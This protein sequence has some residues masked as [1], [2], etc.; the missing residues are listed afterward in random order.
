MSYLLNEVLPGLKEGW[1][2]LVSEVLGFMSSSFG[3]TL[4]VDTNSGSDNN[5]GGSPEKAFATIQAAVTAGTKLT[6][7]IV[8][9]KNMSA[10]DTDPGSYTENIVIPA[11]KW[12]MRIIGDGF[13]NRTQGG[14]PQLKVGSTT[15]QALLTIR[16]PGVTIAGLGFNGTGATGG[17]I[18]L[19][20]DGSTKTA[21]GTS[22][23]GCHFK[24][25]VGT[26][27]TNAATGGAIQW[28]AAGG[29]WQVR[30]A[31]NRFYKNVGDIVLLGT[32]GS[33]PQDVIIEDNVFS[34]PAANVDCNLYLAGGSGMNGVVIRNNDFPCFP[35]IGS[36]TNAKQLALT[37]CVGSLVGNTFGCSAKTFGAT[38]DNLV[39][40]TV[41][42]SNNYQECA[43]AASGEIGRT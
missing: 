1:K 26:T 41:L 23:I 28:S 39:P 42:M 6:T 13:E 27:A 37:G 34:G 10:G 9:A 15:T 32:S 2:V 19:D 3:N 24:N 40:T 16:A 29:A 12:G 43:A 25:C 7:V 20:D 22:I 35:A 38:G 30:I 5:D 21:F 17:G 14:L 33:Q 11:A 18:L 8:K 31:G 4:F 36:G